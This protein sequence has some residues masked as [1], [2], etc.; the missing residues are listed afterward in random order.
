MTPNKLMNEN[1]NEIHYKPNNIGGCKEHRDYK[2]VENDL[3]DPKNIDCEIHWAIDF[4]PRRINLSVFNQMDHMGV[5]QHFDQNSC[6]NL[7][8]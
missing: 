5:S 7:H 8:C 6:V 1:S 2:T 4:K 3:Q